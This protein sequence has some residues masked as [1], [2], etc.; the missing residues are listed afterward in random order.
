VFSALL[1][2]YL[3]F[4]FIFSKLLIP[5]FYEDIDKEVLGVYSKNKASISI[6]VLNENYP[7]INDIVSRTDFSDIGLKKIVVRNI[8]DKLFDTIYSCDGE[9]QHY[10]WAV[11]CRKKSSF[12]Y[13]VPV[14]FT[15]TPKAYLILERDINILNWAPYRLIFFGLAVLFF[16]AVIM[17]FGF[18]LFFKLKISKPTE[19]AVNQIST[20]K[21]EEEFTDDLNHLSFREVYQVANLLSE[22]TVQLN[23]INKLATIGLLSSQLAHDI[24]KPMSAIKSVLTMLPAKKFDEVFINKA[25]KDVNH[26]IKS[27][28]KMIDE[29]LE[30]SRTRTNQLQN[31]EIQS[32]IHNT[33][34]ESCRYCNKQNPAEISFK[35]YL[36]HQHQLL[37]DVEKI[38]RLFSNIV[39]NAME[40]IKT[41]GTIFFYTEEINDPIKGALIK[42]KIANDGPL[43]PTENLDK[44]F[45]DFFT[46]DKTKGTGLGLSI[47]KKIVLEH[48]GS[49]TANSKS[50]HGKNFTEFEFI[51]PVSKDLSAL[52]TQE[53]F[54]DTVELQ[55][56]D[57]SHKEKNGEASEQ[58]SKIK[59][60]CL[61]LNRKINVAIIDDEPIFRNNLR[62]LIVMDEDLKDLIEVYEI[63]SAENAVELFNKM[64]FDFAIVDID[65]GAKMMDG[66]E[67]GRFINKNFQN[68]KYI[69]HSNRPKKQYERI[70]YEI[71]AE[72]FVPKPLG[73]ATL[74]KFLSKI[75]S[76]VNAMKKE[77]RNEGSSKD[78]TLFIV[79]DMEITRI[80]LEDTVREALK[81]SKYKLTVHTFKTPDEV[82]DGVKKIKPDIVFT[83]YDFAR[84]S[85]LNGL[86]LAK[87]LRMMNT[88][89]YMYLV[90]NQPAEYTEKLVKNLGIKSIFRPN[91]SKEEL[92]MLLC[93]DLEDYYLKD[94]VNPE[95]KK[96]MYEKVAKLFH[97]INKP[98]VNAG[99]VY[100]SCKSRILEHKDK[101]AMTLFNE[102]TPIILQYMQKYRKHLESFKNNISSDFKKQFS[103]TYERYQKQ[104][105][106]VE[107]LLKKNSSILKNM[108][109]LDDILTELKKTQEDN[110]RYTSEIMRTI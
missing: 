67:F 109:E 105:T 55:A 51:L 63:S 47:A 11:I 88:K 73:C 65:L 60:N 14:K 87:A 46:S 17:F 80:Y 90:T 91:I 89:A 102:S 5:Y 50:E 74:L 104:F 98:A 72:G 12:V 6:A 27:A 69:I 20:A 99:M 31:C 81:D 58:L 108:E 59:Q 86:D 68:T 33:L 101:D 52:S 70:V 66:I 77:K 75:N 26:S 53:L 95:D 22:K 56:Y 100:Y 8:N 10:D 3:L 79:D 34:V 19:M 45:E 103:D 43:I 92:R 18:M 44:I 62:N 7:L 61:N 48:G 32:V 94:S 16:V 2:S 71:G 76:E 97:D 13:N 25:I 54:K 49:I 106:H 37:V 93:N 9:I 23:K 84:T 21:N 35:Y 82:I 39:C 83:D 110:N 42:I 29:V 78:V 36:R 96:L 40:A 107:E 64:S 41:S 28:E 15:T 30:F 38:N 1:L 24:R 57:K 4:F 85:E